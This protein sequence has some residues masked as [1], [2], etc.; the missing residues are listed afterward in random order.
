MQSGSLRLW[1]RLQDNND[2]PLFL[3]AGSDSWL[4]SSGGRSPVEGDTR[5]N[6][7]GPAGADRRLPLAQRGFPINFELIWFSDVYLSLYWLTR[8]RY[9]V[10]VQPLLVLLNKRWVCCSGTF[11]ISCSRVIRNV[12]ATV[13]LQPSALLKEWLSCVFSV[14]GVVFCGVGSYQ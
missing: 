3:R 7:T 13:N 12:S 8:L 11:K 1:Q 14:L 2:L 10:K 4:G 9:A 6:Q 5:S